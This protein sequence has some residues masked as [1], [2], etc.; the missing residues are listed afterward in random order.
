[1]LAR[2][3]TR[4]IVL[5]KPAARDVLVHNRGIVSKIYIAKA[6]TRARFKEGERIDITESYHRATWDLLRKLVAE[7]SDAA[8]AKVS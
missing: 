5:P 6:G 3:L 7:I 2:L 8:L 1:M 4:L